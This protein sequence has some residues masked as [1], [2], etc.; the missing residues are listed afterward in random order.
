[1][2]TPETAAS[3]T[4]ATIIEFINPTA[5]SRNCSIIKGK[6]KLKSFLL[7]NKY[8]TL[9]L[10]LNFVDIKLVKFTP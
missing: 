1:M 6:N 2:D 3:P 4:E 9:L 7:E 8:S 5:N 10:F